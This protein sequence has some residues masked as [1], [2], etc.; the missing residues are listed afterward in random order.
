MTMVLVS[1]SIT[2]TSRFFISFSRNFKWRARRRKSL[3]ES[4]LEISFRISF[5]LVNAIDERNVKVKADV[6]GVAWGV[7]F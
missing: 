1:C 7:G 3:V 2:D 5:R 6:E 4:D